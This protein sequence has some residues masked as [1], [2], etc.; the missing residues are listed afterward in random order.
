MAVSLLAR[1]LAFLGDDLRAQVRGWRRGGLDRLA[2]AWAARPPRRRLAAQALAL[3]LL[4]VGLVSLDARGRLA[5]RLPSVRDWQALTALLE[6]DA[7]PGDLVAILPPWLERARE[8]VPARLPLL[9]SSTLD[10]EWLPGV[11]RVWLVT[12]GGVTSFGPRLPLAARTATADPQQ[13]GQ[14][15]VTR[16]DLASPVTTLYALADQPGAPTRW[17]EVQGVVRRCLELAARPG[18]P[19]RLAWPRLKLGG[20]LAGHAALLGGPSDGQAG[21]RVRLGEEPPV[22]IEVAARGGW[23]PFR[24]DT[25]RFAG[26][27]LAL[28]LEADLPAG[29]ALC[30]EAVVL[31]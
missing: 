3:S 19:A 8:A 14:L 17:S 18:E 20:A 1:L 16:L 23:I 7:R 12:A 9:A 25:T 24:V 31:P 4:L 27:G 11:R 22:S 13:V 28:A 29:A 10:A 26:R 15:R 5:G 21:L 6:R 2:R 30:L